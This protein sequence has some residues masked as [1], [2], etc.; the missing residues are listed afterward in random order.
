MAVG[1]ARCKQRR[2][3]LCHGS[4]RSLRDW[5]AKL[6]R[7]KEWDSM[8]VTDKKAMI[9]EHKSKG[10]GRGVRRSFKMREVASVTDSV[11]LAN[12]AEFLTE[13]QFQ[14]KLQICENLTHVLSCCP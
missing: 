9:I 2:C 12:N 14:T 13:L 5:Y 4:R 1:G 8:S 11:K 6:D 10:N 3:K 7:L